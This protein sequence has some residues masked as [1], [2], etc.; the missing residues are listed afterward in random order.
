MN[1]NWSPSVGGVILNS[2]SLLSGEICW[3]PTP[4]RYALANPACEIGTIGT[5]AMMALLASV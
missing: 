5:S 3:S 1:T 2:S 4:A